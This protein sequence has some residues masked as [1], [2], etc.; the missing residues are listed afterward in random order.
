VRVMP[1][2]QLQSLFLPGST[3]HPPEIAAGP[4]RMRV[5]CLGDYSGKPPVLLPATQLT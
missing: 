3:N 1:V 4:V 5:Y 2:F